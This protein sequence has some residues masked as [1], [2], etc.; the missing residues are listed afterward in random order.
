[1]S[2]IRQTSVPCETLEKTPPP[3]L[4]RYRLPGSRLPQP[5]DAALCGHVKTEP[6]RFGYAEPRTNRPGCQVCAIC[7]AMSGESW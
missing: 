6:N 5:G 1:M 4:H 3:I 2:D 7:R